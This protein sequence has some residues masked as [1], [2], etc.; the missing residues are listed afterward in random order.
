MKEKVTKENIKKFWSEHKLEIIGTGLIVVGVVGYT[1]GIR[2][3]KNWEKSLANSKFDWEGFKKGLSP[4]EQALI[5][6]YEEVDKIREG[7]NCYVPISVDEFK[8]MNN[9]YSI[10]SCGQG[11]ELMDVKGLIAFGNRI[12]AES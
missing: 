2:Q 5:S 3:I 12:E 1:V 6:M 4:D 8:E 7:C 10:L 11:T 9:G